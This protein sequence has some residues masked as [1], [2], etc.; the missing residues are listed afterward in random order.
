LCWVGGTL[1]HLQK[2][3][4]YIKYTILEF[5]L[6]ILLFS[7][8]SPVPGIV[9]TDITFH[10]HSSTQYLHYIH[11]PTHFTPSF[12]LPVVSTLPYHGPPVLWFLEK[13]EKTWHLCLFKKATQGVSLWDFYVYTHYSPIW[14]ISSIFLLYTLVPSLWCLNQWKILYSFLYRKY[15][16]HSHLFNFFLLF[17]LFHMWAPLSMSCFSYDCICSRSVIHIWEK[18]CGFWSSEPGLLDSDGLYLY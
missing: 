17:P 12:S 3:L 9:S 4:H 2:F 14:F 8:L 16:N 13:K 10:V 7:P 18:S 11:T 6:S 15:I 5:T 1:W